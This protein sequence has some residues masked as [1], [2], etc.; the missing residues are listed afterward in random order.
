MSLRDRSVFALQDELD[1]LIGAGRMSEALCLVRSVVERITSEPLCAGRVMGARLLDDCCQKIGAVTLA[2]LK[3]PLRP[4]NGGLRVYLVT[5]LQKSGGHTRVLQDLIRA[6]PAHVRHVVLSTEWLGGS[7]REAVCQFGRPVNV[8][9]EWCGGGAPQERLQWLQE[10]LRA[11]APEKV[12][13][14]NHHQDSLVVSAVQPGQ[15]YKLIFY[16]HGDFHLSL[17]LYIPYAQHIDLHPMGFHYCRDRLGIAG[18]LYLPL[19]AND[20]GCRHESEFLKTG[21]LVTCT[22]AHATKVE[23][24]YVVPYTEMV[25]RILAATGGTH[26]HIGRL[27]RIGLWRI[28]RNLKRLGIDRA[29]FRHIPY[30]PNLSKA[31]QEI[32]V[33]VYVASFPYG[34]ART[35]VEVMSAAIPVVVHDH[36]ARRLLGGMDIAYPEA[37]AWRSPDELLKGLKRFSRDELIR[38]SRAARKHYLAYHDLS[39]LH[40][41]DETVHAKIPTMSLR[42]HVH[43]E[44][45]DGMTIVSQLSVWGVLW[46]T[47][48]RHRRWL[49][50]YLR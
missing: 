20:E 21:A 47:V 10:R 11:L 19:V 25:A 14:F 39:Q 8:T 32:G 49:V 26:V 16:H 28:R 30:V 9:F 7:D 46:R 38:Q 17:G 31:M 12:W 42:V 37:M 41:F 24:P 35:L 23:V 18:N 50:K 45:Q 40:D 44:L 29:R 3:Q 4:A 48:Y 34:G 33:D 2:G 27:T 13:M 15:G 6:A 5:K 36:Y 43:D 1:R 22:A